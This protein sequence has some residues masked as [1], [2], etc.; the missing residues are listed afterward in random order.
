MGDNCR[1]LILTAKSDKKRLILPENMEK[2]LYYSH[3]VT[4]LKRCF[5]TS[6]SSTGIFKIVHWKVKTRLQLVEFILLSIACGLKIR[7]R[8][9]L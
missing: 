4:T 5:L 1:T 3:A 2:T 9:W 7:R 6:D 8:V